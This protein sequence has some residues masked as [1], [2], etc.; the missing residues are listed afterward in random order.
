LES[1]IEPRLQMSLLDALHVM[2]DGARIATDP[3]L[4]TLVSICVLYERFHL[5]EGRGSEET[6]YETV[7]AKPTAA[8]DAA[9]CG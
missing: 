1:V 8:S 4:M 9:V 3:I 7:L 6:G 2:N 5:G